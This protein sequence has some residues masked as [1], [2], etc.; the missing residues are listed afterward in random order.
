MI[1][2]AGDVSCITGCMLRYTDLLPVAPETD[3]PGIGTVGDLIAGKFMCSIDAARSEIVITGT[4]IPH[5]T[6]SVRSIANRPGKPGWTLVFC[7]HTRGPA[8]FATGESVL[9]W[10]D[11]ARGIIHGLFD[12]VVPGGIVQGLR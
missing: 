10:F 12:L 2:N 4:G 11:D 5:T 6:G 1:A 8:R 3:V 7:L 9:Q